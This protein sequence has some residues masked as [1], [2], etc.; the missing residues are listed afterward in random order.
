MVPGL[1]ASLNEGGFGAGGF[2]I[3]GHTLLVRG[4]LGPESEEEFQGKLKEL[5]AIDTE[6]YVIDLSDVSY[7]SS[8]YVGP[9][10]LLMV[11][12]RRKGRPVTVLAREKAASLLHLGGLDRLAEVRVVAE[13][14]TKPAEQIEVKR[15]V[16]GS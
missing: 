15:P 14:G 1:G 5:L 8:G 6:E 2:E 9:I 11:D 3:R 4:E 12:A 16:S 10:A 7:M 13:N